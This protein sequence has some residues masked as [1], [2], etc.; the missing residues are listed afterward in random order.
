[1]STVT[2]RSR[3][4]DDQG[5]SLILA[6]VFIVVIGVVLVAVGGLAANAL[7]NTNNT[8]AQRTAT[9]DAENAVTIA[10]QYLRYHYVP[11]TTNTCLPAG[12]QIPSS[13][14]RVSSVTPVQVYCT[15]NVSSFSSTTRTVNFYACAPAVSAA[16]CIGQPGVRLVFAQV[17]Y[18]DLN[19]L[20]ISNCNSTSTPTDTSC[21]L[22]MSVETW[23]VTG[24]DT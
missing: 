23:D 4:G 21:G 1:M 24:A 17:A 3:R 13:D 7:L 22:S 19:P 12:V 20:G 2:T 6:L 8:R 15:Q 11:P 5:T 18:N 16:T 14:P 9:E 10:M